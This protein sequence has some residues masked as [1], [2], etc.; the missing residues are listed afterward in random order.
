MLF[1]MTDPFNWSASNVRSWVMWQIEQYNLPMINLDY[2]NMN[3][4]QLCSLSEDEF[5][6]RASPAVGELL[7]AQLDIWKTACGVRRFDY[8]NNYAPLN[9]KSEPL[10]RNMM[11][12][13]ECPS[14]SS[15]GFSCASP[16]SSYMGSSGCDRSISGETIH[17][18]LTSDYGSEGA[19]SDGE[20]IIFSSK[21]HIE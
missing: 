7:F 6:V 11:V 12:K 1:L 2:F 19:Q 10:D 17:S 21:Y 20:F 5:R 18:L 14:P 16:S 15:S 4:I 9:I 13:M 8:D 3:G